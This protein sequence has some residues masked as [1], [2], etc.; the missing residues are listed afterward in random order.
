MKAGSKEKFLQP[1]VHG[2][3]VVLFDK[4]GAVTANPFDYEAHDAMLQDRIAHLGAMFA[5]M[6]SYVRKEIL[7]GNILDAMYFYPGTLRPLVELLRIKYDP[8]RY[9]WGQ[10]YLGFYLPP[11]DRKKLESLNLIKDIADLDQKQKVAQ[12]WV[13]Q[14]LDDLSEGG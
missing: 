8:T 6:Q 12:E 10:R 2:E 7:R 3:P 11:A 13:K 14:L 5:R 1:E 9:N 4:T